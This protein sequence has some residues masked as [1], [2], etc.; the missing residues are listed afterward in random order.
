L[1]ALTKASQEIEKKLNLIDVFPDFEA[2]GLHTTDSDYLTPSEA[3][4]YMDKLS[5]DM[6]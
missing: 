6:S 1:T 3:E 5:G 2:F 4:A